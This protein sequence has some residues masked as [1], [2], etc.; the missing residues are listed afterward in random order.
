[1]R[2]AC[3]EVRRCGSWPGAPS[4]RLPERRAPRGGRLQATPLCGT[5]RSL[6]LP[7]CHVKHRQ[8]L[9][10]L[11]QIAD[12]FRQ[13]RELDGRSGIERRGVQRHQRSQPAGINVVDL[14]Q[15]EHNALV[16]RIACFTCLPQQRRFFAKNNPAA[17]LDHQNS[18]LPF[19]RNF[20]LHKNAPLSAAARPD[21]AGSENC[22][23]R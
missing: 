12:A 3:R 10:H 6:R 4:L 20:Q 14:A 17:A 11:Q 9:G 18:V 5:I 1:M 2:G 23:H 21:P 22:T 15:I 8:Q 19:A 13:V 7:S 16:I